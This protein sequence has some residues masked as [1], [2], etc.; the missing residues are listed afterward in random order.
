[1]KIHKKLERAQIVQYG[2][3]YGR[4]GTCTELDLLMTMKHGYI[5]TSLPSAGNLGYVRGRHQSREM[6]DPIHSINLHKS[7]R[8]T[9]SFSFAE[10]M[11]RFSRVEEHEKDSNSKI[12][13]TTEEDGDFRVRDRSSG[14]KSG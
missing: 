3:V 2:Q 5:N 11:L 10:M 12:A 7:L 9:S 6:E 8:N 13:F 4:E 14:R 1:M